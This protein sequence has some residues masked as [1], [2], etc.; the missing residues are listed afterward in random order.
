LFL[1][2]SFLITTGAS[3]PARAA[4]AILLWHSWRD[5]SADLLHNWVTAFN[6]KQTD[7]QIDA[8]YVPFQQMLSQITTT[9]SDSRPDLIL[10]PSDWGNTL[11]VN[12]LISPIEGVVDPKLAFVQPARDGAT[13]G[14][15]LYAI[16]VSLEGTVL[17]YNKTLVGSTPLPATLDDLLTQ[18]QTLSS[19]ETHDHITGLVMDTSFFNSAGLFFAADGKLFNGVQVGVLAGS[20]L[21]DYLTQ[22][23]ALYNGSKDKGISFAGGIATFSGGKAAYLVAGSWHYSDLKTAMGAALGVAKLPT[24]NGNTWS[25]L[26]RTTQFYFLAK[27][28]R[29]SYALDFAQYVATQGADLANKAGLISAA[30]DTKPDDANLTAIQTQLSIGTIVPNRRE[31]IALWVPLDQAVADVTVGEKPVDAEI[32]ITGDA[33]NVAIGALSPQNP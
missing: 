30:P 18:S 27:T 22:M 32:G 2:L 11:V 13:L 20:A 8:Q 14:G 9:S 24:V 28:L 3:R 25:P 7:F 15:T 6:A 21:K 17:Y 31:M 23:S 33:I 29:L 26:V 19:A 1:L 10:G 5:D 12:N 4:T 16:P